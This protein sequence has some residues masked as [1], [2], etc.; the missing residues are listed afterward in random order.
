MFA[1]EN[2]HLA[3]LTYAREHECPWNEQTLLR[4]AKS[5]QLECLQYAREHGCP[6]T[7]K[8]ME[9]FQRRDDARSR[10]IVGMA[11]SRHNEGGHI[12]GRAFTAL[13][14]EYADASRTIQDML[15]DHFETNDDDM[16]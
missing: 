10:L 15:R 13:Y 11:I 8:W 7:R 14:R 5:K 12:S 6:L 2:G 1:A 9:A 16:M 3:C 4:A